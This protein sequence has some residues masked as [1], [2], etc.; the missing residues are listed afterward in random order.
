MLQSMNLQRKFWEKGEKE[1][2]EKKKK[3]K[4]KTFHFLNRLSLALKRFIVLVI[5][6][7]QTFEVPSTMDLLEFWFCQD[8]QLKM[9][10]IILRI[11]LQRMFPKHLK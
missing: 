4:K 6:L 11:S 5:I 9:I 3:K 8:A 2:K 7:V 1:E 10:Q